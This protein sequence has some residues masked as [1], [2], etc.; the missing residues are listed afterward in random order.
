MRLYSL[1]QERDRLR[2]FFGFEVN[3]G[4]EE[5]GNEEFRL[6]SQSSPKVL[7]RS[8]ELLL[9]IAGEAKVAVDLGDFRHHLRQF[10]IEPFRFGV[11]T[12]VQRL[13]SRGRHLRRG[14][15]RRIHSEDG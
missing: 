14:L 4:Q 12:P 11:I 3:L 8:R 13:S 6:E 7:L 5:I 10:G 9:I 15:C 2:I 1:S